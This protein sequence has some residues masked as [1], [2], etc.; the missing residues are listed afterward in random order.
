MTALEYESPCLPESTAKV[1]HA[2][3]LAAGLRD[4]YTT[5]RL[6]QSNRTD[7]KRQTENHYK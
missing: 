1:R 2:A 3:I 4:Y 7:H 5:L 6:E